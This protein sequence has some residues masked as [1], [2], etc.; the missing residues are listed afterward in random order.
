MQ[1]LVDMTGLPV[2]NENK[3]VL[4]GISDVIGGEEYKVI[5]A[6]NGLKLSKCSAAHARINIEMAD[7]NNEL[8]VLS[9]LSTI[10]SEV[11]WEI[12]FKK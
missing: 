5:I 6:L 8:A 9:I 2:W 1:G 11:K 3:K 12:S 10:N 4:S 7:K